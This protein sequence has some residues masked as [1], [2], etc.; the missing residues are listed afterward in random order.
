M[1]PALH[2]LLDR[3]EDALAVVAAALLLIAVLMVSVEVGARYFFNNPLSWTF[4]VTEY[5][6]LYIPCLGMGWLARQDGHV[7]I[8][9]VTA[10]LREPLRGR[11]ARLVALCVSAACLFVAAWGAIATWESYQKA[12]RIEA[13]LQTPQFL[14]YAAIPLGFFICGLEYARKALQSA[15]RPTELS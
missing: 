7:S 13:I 10:R 14:I 1:S 15:A 5:F 3:I 6:L 9:V 8:D 2:R 11:L 4:E 12:A